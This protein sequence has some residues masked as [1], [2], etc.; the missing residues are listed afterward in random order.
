MITDLQ[1]FLGGRLA[2]L[3][4]RPESSRE[5][6]FRYDA[7]YREDPSNPP[8][9]LR[10]PL[11]GRDEYLISKWLDGLLPDNPALRRE[12][13]SKHSYG[14]ADSMSLL[15]SPVG[16]DCAGSVQFCEVGAEDSITERSSGTHWHSSADIAQWAKEAKRGYRPILGD[17]PR[18]SLA[19]WQTKVGLYREDERW[20]T[21]FGD[22]PTTWILKIG[23]DPHPLDTMSW[24][25]AE[26][27]EHVTMVTARRLGLNAAHTEIH[28]FEGERVLAVQRYDRVQVQQQWRRIHQEDLCQALDLS[29][30]DKYQRDGGPGPFTISK[31][32]NQELVDGDRACAQFL[33]GVIINWVLGGT[34]GHAKNYSLLFQGDSARFAPLYDLMSDFPYLRCKPSKCETAMKIGK[35]YSLAACD[36]PEVWAHTA[37]RFLLDPRDALERIER[38]LANCPEAIETVINGLNPEDQDVPEMGTLLSTTQKRCTALIDRFAGTALRLWNAPSPPVDPLTPH[39]ATATA[40]YFSKSEPES[41]PMPAPVISSTPIICGY[42]TGVD[43]WC[44]QSLSVEPCPEH[45]NST[46]SS[47]VRSRNKAL[48]ADSQSE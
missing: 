29:P 43:E 2:G 7:A 46:G 14:A 36:A 38:I 8:L 44:Q 1:V 20:G 47:K 10:C 37:H 34:D 18:Y 25:N 3:A 31:F 15:A 4:H 24:P 6:V 48:Q 12:W 13:A 40:E 23:I 30:G 27:V 39:T 11:V 21:P 5:T 9:S 22:L 26:L 41:P 33:D 17:F 16:L 45:P 19:G 32:L 28:R 42:P 35:D